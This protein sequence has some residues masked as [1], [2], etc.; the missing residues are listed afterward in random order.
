MSRGENARGRERKSERVL[1]DV[2]ARL[3][4]Y[5][6]VSVS[7][8]L[9]LSVC[10]CVGVCVNFLFSRYL[11]LK[12]TWVEKKEEEGGELRKTV[13]GEGMRVL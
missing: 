7:V 13:K 5:V 4:V 9:S 12:F 6:S 8:S 2:V 3:L 10:V 1:R 11:M